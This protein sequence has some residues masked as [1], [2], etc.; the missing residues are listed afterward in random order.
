[1]PGPVGNS[2]SSPR[3]SCKR[4][5]RATRDRR[6]CPPP[7]LRRAFQKIPAGRAKLQGTRARRR[8]DQSRQRPQLA[9]WTRTENPHPNT[10]QACRPHSKGFRNAAW[11]GSSDARSDPSTAQLPRLRGHAQGHRGGLA[12]R[13][14]PRA[15]G[16]LTPPPPPPSLEGPGPQVMQPR[17]PGR[18]PE[19]SAPGA[20]GRG[21]PPCWRGR[22]TKARARARP[23][24]HP[25]PGQQGALCRS[26]RR[27]DNAPGRR[28]RG[29][30]PSSYPGPA[31]T[32]APRSLTSRQPGPVC[33]PRAHR[34]TL[35]S[36]PGLT[37]QTAPPHPRS[38]A[39]AA[40]P[41]PH[42]A[43]ALLSLTAPA[44]PPGHGPGPRSRLRRRQWWGRGPP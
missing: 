44:A 13:A 32:R 5:K 30:S 36:R 43:R 40:R 33:R 42:G 27:P 9:A 28:C 18:R 29:L 10:G 21:R 37:S 15:L 3:R 23:E 34:T 19:Q 38:A 24:P 16:R 17:R 41:R 4:R 26:A 2:T 7:R 35:R 6:V 25:Q 39:A 14:D 22:Q 11:T 31:G 8:H 1:M 12:G 20:A